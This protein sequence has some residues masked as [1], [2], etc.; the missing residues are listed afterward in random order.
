M[1]WLATWFLFRFRVTLHQIGKVSGIRWPPPDEQRRYKIVG[2][3]RN[4][5]FGYLN[6][7][8][9]RQ[10]FVLKQISWVPKT[11]DGK[12]MT[13]PQEMPWV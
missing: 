7:C 4:D 8:V 10:K 9:T 13:I 6:D 11:S 12:R 1:E 5:V 3:W 2:F